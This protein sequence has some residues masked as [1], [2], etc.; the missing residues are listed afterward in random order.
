MASRSKIDAITDNDCSIDCAVKYASLSNPGLAANRGV[1]V[2][3]THA[4]QDARSGADP[5]PTPNEQLS[6]QA[7]G[8]P[9]RRHCRY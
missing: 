8:L 9:N 5:D 2:V 6:A 7:K 1:P 3:E 4:V